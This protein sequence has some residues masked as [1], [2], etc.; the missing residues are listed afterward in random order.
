M[1]SSTNWATET[2]PGYMP[3]Y[4]GR[5]ETFG[6]RI[7]GMHVRKKR[8]R[9]IRLM[10]N[11]RIWFRLLSDKFQNRLHYLPRH[12]LHGN[13]AY[14]FVDFCLTTLN[15]FQE[16]VHIIHPNKVILIAP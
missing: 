4:T 11:G 12:L 1:R 14:V 2:L 3:T 5:K 16:I 6:M 7:T 15:I 9:R 13:V 10:K 8:G